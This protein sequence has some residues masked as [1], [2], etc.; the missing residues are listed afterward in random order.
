[1]NAQDEANIHMP[2][3]GRAERVIVIS[4]MKSGTHLVKELAVALGYN[5]YGHV[6]VTPDVRPALDRDTRWRIAQMVY[7]SEVIANLKSQPEAVFNDSTDRAWEALAWSWQLRFGIPLRTLYSTELI[8]T[9]MVEETYRRTAGS[10]FNETPAGVCWMLHEFD[11]SKI[12]GSFLREWAETGEP[13]II[14]NYRDPRDTILSLIN[15]LCGQTRHGL[16]AFNNLPVFSRILLAK[17]SLEE[18]LT[19]ALSDSSFPCHSDHFKRMLWLLHH[20]N[21]CKTSFEDLVGPAG[22]GS[23]ESQVRATATLI[24]FLGIDDRSPEDVATVL[25]NRNAFSFHQG[26]VGTWRKVFT[27]EHCRLAEDRLGE[28]LSLYGYA[29]Q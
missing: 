10:S 19:Y 5:L 20:P 14:F 7:N 4:L 27:A 22:G 13:R 23:A 21:V 15:F 9:G 16:S 25:F 2:R 11:I 29:L 18:K 28:V 6:R 26:Q 1:M 17:T 3:K 24:D 8:N 12:D